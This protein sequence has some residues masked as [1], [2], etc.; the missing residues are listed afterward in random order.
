M[1]AIK[2]SDTQIAFLREQYTEEL[3]NAEKYVEQVKD[4]LKKLG[5]E[6]DSN[7]EA[8]EKEIKKSLKKEKK[9]KVKTAEVREPKKRGRKPKAVV[10]VAEETP[11]VP[12][13]PKKRGRRPRIQVEVSKP[14]AQSA[15]PVAQEKRKRGRPA[16]EKKVVKIVK[17]EKVAAKPKVKKVKLAKVKAEP[18]PVAVV[19][20]TV[21]VVENKKAVKKVVAKK[22]AVKKPVVKKAVVKKAVAKKKAE[23][24]KKVQKPAVVA[25]VENTETAPAVQ[26]VSE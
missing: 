12:A 2:F 22:P 11:A 20:E 13:E 9:Q 14:V 25:V 15:E 4:I 18:A 16:K 17:K 8:S 19:A 24:K 21:A 23:P 26:Q 10:A 1:K 5:G 6:S 7:E 3:A